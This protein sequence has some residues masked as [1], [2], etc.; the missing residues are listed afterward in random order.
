MRKKY[1]SALLFGALLFASAGTFTSC[2]DYDDDIDGLR[3]EITDLKSAVTEL[4]NAVQNGKYVTAVSGNGNVITFTFSDGSTTPITI[5]TESGEPSQTVTIGED[6]EVI[7]NGEG[8]GYY[9]TK[10]PSE[11]EVEAGLVKKGANGTWEVLGEDG[12]YTDTKIPVSGISVSGSDAEGYTFT[13]VNAN[14][15]SQTVKLPSAASAIT[16]IEVATA[17]SGSSTKVEINS[18]EFTFDNNNSGLIKNRG[19]WKGNKALPDDGDYIYSSPTELD[20]RINP[21]NADASSV[22]FYLTNTKNQDLNPIVFQA[23]PEDGDDP[24]GIGQMQG[25]AGNQGNGLWTLTMENVVV[26]KN[27]VSATQAEIAKATVSGS[28]WAYALNAGHASRSKYSL[29]V[30][31]GA[32]KKLSAINL[33]QSKSQ[34]DNAG[35]QVSGATDEN[36]SGNISLSSTSAVTATGDYKVGIPVKVNGYEA[37][38]LYDMYL[39][40]SQTDRDVYGITFDQD[41]HTFTIGKN[42][43]VSTI[44]ASFTLIVWTV[45]NNGDMFKNEVVVKIDTEINAAAE[46]TTISHNV[47]QKDADNNFYID[48]ATMKTALGDNLNQWMQNVDLNNASGNVITYGLYTDAACNTKLTASG[49]SFD[50]TNVFNAEVVEKNNKDAKETTDEN[51]ANYIRINV[52]NSAVATYNASAV[53]G[54]ELALDKTY[55]VKVTFQTEG[56]TPT[57]LNSIIVP[58]E[59]HAPALSELFAVNDAFLDKTD[60]DVI[61]AYFYKVDGVIA[62]GHKYTIADAGATVNLDRY[63]SKFVSNAK[64]SFAGGKIGE[65]GK[66]ADEL[67]V[68]GCLNYNSVSNTNKDS[69]GDQVFSTGVAGDVKTSTTLGF[70]AVNPG[71]DNGK[72]ANGYGETLTINVNKDFYNYDETLS[73]GWRYTEDGADEYSFKIRLMSPIYEGSVKPVEG[74]SITINAN[75]L[76][77]GASITQDMISGY[78]Y[79]NNS[80]SAV[81]DD[82]TNYTSPTLIYNTAGTDLVTAED[83][84]H[85][86]IATV[87]PGTNKYFEDVEVYSAYTTKDGVVPGEFKVYGSSISQTATEDMPFTVTDAWGYVLEEKVPVTIVVNK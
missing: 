19:D 65:T 69:D 11:A 6:G 17:T 15:E 5:E 49:I 79:N 3:T 75:D 74:S 67:F 32:A 26:D 80:F 9:T 55:Y 70:S 54:S 60:K 29:Y 43:D 24:M 22:P 25:R 14:G 51:K 44:Q 68:W 66:T 12:E 40:V 62:N 21:V 27:D 71:I 52:K 81:P 86:Q 2:K 50:G 72:P 82:G 46:Y 77:K 83:Y 45:A 53:A 84:V 31:T 87:I 7:I 35:S 4:Q 73:D 76:S 16:S 33:S 59:F 28:E 36:V 47:N 58:V 42:P 10:T 63:F 78:D 13:V 64:V 34:L 61:N 18:T 39:E 20:I 57:E 23:S 38:A 37:A 85:P 1:L 48:L 41:K 30:N 56:T 8:T